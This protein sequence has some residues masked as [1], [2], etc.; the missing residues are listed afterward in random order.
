MTWSDACS[1][2]SLFFSVGSNSILSQYGRPQLSSDGVYVVFSEKGNKHLCLTFFF[3]S[4]SLYMW[5]V[6]NLDMLVLSK[7]TYNNV[8]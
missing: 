1:L 7:S 8:Q 4:Y 6:F 5:P 3:S 2:D